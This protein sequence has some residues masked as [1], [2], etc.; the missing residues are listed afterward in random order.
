MHKLPGF[1]PRFCGASDRPVLASIPATQ[2][3]LPN[4][5]PEVSVKPGEDEASQAGHAAGYANSCI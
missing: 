5:L 3:A 2:A 4:S 1:G